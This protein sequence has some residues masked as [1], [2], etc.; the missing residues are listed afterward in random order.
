MPTEEKLVEILLA[1]LI[2]FAGEQLLK[3]FFD[4]QNHKSE[5]RTNYRRRRIIRKRKKT[6]TPGQGKK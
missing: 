5:P 4:K 6:T 1:V 2:N 3:R